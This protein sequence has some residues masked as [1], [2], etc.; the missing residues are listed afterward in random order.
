MRSFLLKVHIYAGLLCSS[1]LLIFGISSL[2]FNHGFGKP[3][4]EKVVWQRSLKVEDMPDNEALSASVRDALGL[5]GWPVTWEIH[6][7]DRRNLR[8]SLERPGKKYSIHVLFDENRVRVEETRT[9]FWAVINAL[10]AHMGLPSSGFMNLWAAYTELCTW[11]VLFSAAS[12]VYFW[13]QRRSE[14]LIGWI[15]LGCAS[16][17]SL[18]FMGYVWWRG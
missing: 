12:G 14:R 16:G 5:I 11:V 10:H 8:F 15:L 2:N 4:D 7:D 13:T 1:Y 3:G 6:R 17:S 9:G 18:L